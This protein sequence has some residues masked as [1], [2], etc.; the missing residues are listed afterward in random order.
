LQ[1]NTRALITFRPDNSAWR[2]P[3]AVSR[4]SLARGLHQRD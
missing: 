3:D 1:R 2:A 4:D